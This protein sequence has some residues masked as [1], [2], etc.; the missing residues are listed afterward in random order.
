MMRTN[1]VPV[2][3]S[4]LLVLMSLAGEVSAQKVQT[5]VVSPA[6]MTKRSPTLAKL[7]FKLT[8]KSKAQARR[9]LDSDSRAKRTAKLLLTALKKLDRTQSMLRTT[10]GNKALQRRMAKQIKSATRLASQLG[11]YTTTTHKSGEQGP[12][13]GGGSGGDGGGSGGEQ[14]PN[15]GAQTMTSLVVNLKLGL[16]ALGPRAGGKNTKPSVGVTTDR[17]AGIAA[18]RSDLAGLLEPV[19][20]R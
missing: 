13:S 4:A 20:S 17:I 14:G 19:A 3:F 16:S 1:L 12:N 15:S 2:F 6:G 9:F 10:P 11:K 7:G 18:R 5:K 8:P